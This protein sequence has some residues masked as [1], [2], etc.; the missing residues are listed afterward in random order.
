MAARRRGF[1]PIQGKIVTR[2]FS[3]NES[4]GFLI[5]C[6]G[7]SLSLQ[8]MVTKSHVQNP[9]AQAYPLVE[10]RG[11]RIDQKES[12]GAAKFFSKDRWRVLTDGPIQPFNVSAAL[13]GLPR[14]CMINENFS[15]VATFRNK[16]GLCMITRKKLQPDRILR[17]KT[18]TLY[19]E[20]CHL[21]TRRH[22]L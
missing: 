9:L 22:L 21:S 6:V 3:L 18:I 7:V 2:N 16:N 1:N 19:F 11:F 8:W 13:N 4:H 15:I 14:D 17:F 12:Y 20:Y 10:E 5:N